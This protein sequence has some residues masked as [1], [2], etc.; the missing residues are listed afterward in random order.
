MHGL[1]SLFISGSL[2]SF[3]FSKVL[4]SDEAVYVLVTLVNRCFVCFIQVNVTA[5]F[6][7]SLYLKV[8]WIRYFVSP[9]A[10]RF[11]PNEGVTILALFRSF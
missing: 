9:C 4:V 7:C 3:C 10:H 2:Q 11:L 6:L 8:L 1:F 5:C